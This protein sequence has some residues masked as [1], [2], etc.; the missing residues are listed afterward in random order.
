MYHMR[1][2]G[3]GEQSGILGKR[4]KKYGFLFRGQSYFS[5]FLVK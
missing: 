4:M 1:S 3:G 5:F 2:Q